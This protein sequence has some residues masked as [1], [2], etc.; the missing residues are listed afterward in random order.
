[1]NEAT[2][3]VDT[4]IQIDYNN[5]SEEDKN[6]NNNNQIQSAEHSSSSCSSSASTSV[7]ATQIL[8]TFLSNNNESKSNAQSNLP[9]QTQYQANKPP[10]FYHNR[11]I[12]STNSSCIGN[13][14][15]SNAT[16]RP[17]FGRQQ[18]LQNVVLNDSYSNNTSNNLSQY[19]QAPF[20]PA[21]YHHHHHHQHNHHHNHH[22]NNHHHHQN[23]PI[24][25]ANIIEKYNRKYN[26]ISFIL[27]RKFD[28]LTLNE[29][30]YLN[31]Q[32]LYNIIKEYITNFDYKS[33][34]ELYKTRELKN[35]TIETPLT[36]YKN[37][38]NC[39][40]FVFTI[41]ETLDFI[42]NG[43]NDDCDKR[44][45]FA[46]NLLEY[47]FQ[48][49]LPSLAEMITITDGDY[50]LRN[51]LHYAA[52][53][54][55]PG[56]VRLMYENCKEPIDDLN[57]TIERL[58]LQ[59][60]YNGN[61]P[62]HIAIKSNSFHFL[63]HL[64]IEKKFQYV[65]QK[66][67]FDTIYNYDGLNVLLLA[68]HSASFKLVQFMCDQLQMN[69]NLKEANKVSKKNCLHFAILRTVA[70]V[71]NEND[72]DEFLVKY[73]LIKYLNEKNC[74]LLYDVCPLIGSI[75]HISASNLIH[76]HILWYLLSEY[77]ELNDRLIN[78]T[79]TIPNQVTTVSEGATATTTTTIQPSLLD[80]NL[81]INQLD[82]KQS[83]SID[84]FIDT[85]IN[86]RNII[87]ST[88]TIY[89]FYRKFLFKNSNFS[90]YN[91]LSMH[92]NDENSYNLL[93]KKCFFKFL[94][95]LNAKIYKLPQIQTRLQLY[96]FIKLL[97][98]M[99]KLNMKINTNV[100]TIYY[101]SFE[102][103]LLKFLNTF[104]FSGDLLD[105]NTIIDHAEC[106]SGGGGNASASSMRKTKSSPILSQTITNSSTSN[107]N[108]IYSIYNE[109]IELTRVIILSGFFTVKFQQK[110]YSFMLDYFKN[111]YQQQVNDASAFNPE[112]LRV[113]S[114]NTSLMSN[115]SKSTLTP[116][117][118]LL[119]ENEN[120]VS[121]DDL[122]DDE[123]V[124]CNDSTKY[125]NIF[126]RLKLNELKQLN[127]KLNMLSLKE[128]CRISVNRSL[129]NRYIFQSSNHN[130]SCTKQNQVYFKLPS[131]YYVY[132]NYLTF[133]LLNDLYGCSA[134]IN[135]NA[136]NDEIFQYI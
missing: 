49:E 125:F 19:K 76:L 131:K 20:K 63:N 110:I 120:D 65:F 18:S 122:H 1:M 9:I 68:I 14:T 129:F 33:I 21:S 105:L 127:S 27:L 102:A 43:K 70:S 8:Q 136:F 5:N 89:T 83:S 60:D 123:F 77:N 84:C 31:D 2:K 88:E 13:V 62:L 26:L 54:D 17:K 45:S 93:I 75:Y 35:L 11:R 128:L 56:V 100:I 113:K 118:S 58:L 133:N 30:V 99:S 117:T 34:I 72:N 74:L 22:H 41:R 101:T 28:N 42:N 25:S 64:I 112:K 134:N 95:K 97:K 10:F 114:L 73:E 126:F 121:N 51:M 24:N 85:L 15:N 108:L 39:N 81:S 130:P 109:L 67:T 106:D 50:P 132:I 119:I 55:Y 36:A 53:Y 96:E 87:P 78:S 46:A 52:Y 86:I 57:R 104:I 79:S 61:T 98:I 69:I 3:K 6:L 111:L 37:S 116:S 124:S 59:T 38:Y 107:E 115:A 90:A 23:Q 40:L 91:E 80:E 103:Y 12:V 92:L 16:N 71:N 135:L 4:L 32:H 48:H 94:C 47:L 7:N 29:S 66:Y 82:F 44:S